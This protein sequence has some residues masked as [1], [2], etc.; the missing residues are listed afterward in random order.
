MDNFTPIRNGIR[1]H[2]SAGNLCPFDLGIY[3]LLHLRADW[4][5]GIFR[6]CALSIAY[7]FND[8][9]LKHHI[10]KSLIRLRERRYI[11]YAKGSGRRGAYEVLIHK[12]D[13]TVGQLRGK[14]LNAWKHGELCRPVYDDWN[15]G[16]TAGERSGSGGGR[17]EE[18]IL[19]LQD[20]ID[21]KTKEKP[22]APA[23][24][25]ERIYQAYPRH[26]GK[27]AALKAIGKAIAVIQEAK[28]ATA[29]DAA[30]FLNSQVVKFANSPAGQ[31]GGYTPHCATW[32]NDGRYFDDPNEW[33]RATPTNVNRKPSINEI[34]ERE[35]SFV[36]AR[37]N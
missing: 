28:R 24:V 4:A 26:V 20:V 18:P 25:C 19:D 34:I 35:Q 3:V 37:A 23:G 13:V 1:E 27:V 17:V 33:R 32:M 8:P 29:E 22:F 21:I 2:I 10:N 15:S 9:S 5:T 30:D 11:N 14:R 6:G 36:R 16:G 12:Y 7:A 31:R